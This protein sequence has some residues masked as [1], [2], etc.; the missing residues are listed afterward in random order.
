VWWDHKLGLL[1]IKT[2]WQYWWQVETSIDR[3][4]YAKVNSLQDL[5][6]EVEGI[7]AKMLSKELQELNQIRY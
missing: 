3:H 6:R 4:A 1:A 5:Q 2:P 7:G